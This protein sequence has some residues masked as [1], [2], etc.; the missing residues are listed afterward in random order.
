MAAEGGAE[1]KK[2]EAQRFRRA[3]RKL[4]T[5]Y[6]E[7][8]LDQYSD[9][10]R[11]LDPLR[12]G[13]PG[14]TRRLLA[15]C[16]MLVKAVYDRARD[17]AANLSEASAFPAVSGLGFA[18]NVCGDYLCYVKVLRLARAEHPGRPSKAVSQ[19]RLLA[20]MAGRTRRAAANAA[21]EEPEGRAED[22]E[23]VEELST[24]C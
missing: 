12:E 7:T 1:A 14:E 8:L 10:A 13:T 6:R 22:D 17:R 18:W 20:A 2:E 19:G 11:A 4:I 24:Q 3:Y 5:H 21:V 15:E 16:L 23:S 9:G